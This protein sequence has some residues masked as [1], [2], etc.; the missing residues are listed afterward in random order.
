MRLRNLG[1]AL[2]VLASIAPALF[3]AVC[4]PPATGVFGNATPPD[5]WDTI[6]PQ[7]IY[8]HH[9]DDPRW[10]GAG[11]I[12]YGDGTSTQ[13]DFRALHDNA[14][15]NLF[16]SWRIFLAPAANANQNTLYVGLDRAGGAGPMVISISL[17][18]LV[19][20][21][22]V[23]GATTANVLNNDGSLGAAV[24]LP[25][26]ANTRVWI[27]NPTANSFA[28]QMQV[29]VSALSV[30]GSNFNMWYEV[31]IGT[32][33]AP[34]FPFAWPRTSFL[35]PPSQLGQIAT[36][37]VPATPGAWDA[38]RLSTGPA[39]PNCTGSGVSL[40]INQIGTTNS[41]SYQVKY[42]TTLPKPVNT[43][44][45]RA[46]N[47]SGGTINAGELHARF[48]LANW[49]SMPGDESGADPNALWATIPGGD[50]IPNA[51]AISNGTTANAGNDNHFDWTLSNAEI[52]PFQNGTRS[53][54]NCLLVELTST[55]GLT[56][57]NNSIRRNMSFVSASKFVHR[58]EISIKGLTPI[59]PLGRDVYLLIDTANMPERVTT[60]PPP[61]PPGILDN[62]L[63]LANGQQ[64][65]PAQ[66]EAAAAA[67]QITQAQLDATVPTYR[68]HVFYDS[69][70]VINGH[71]ILI[72]QSGF[73]Y[74]VI[75]DG[76]LLGWAHQTV[77]ED[78]TL[79]EIA[80]NFYKISHVPNDGVVHVITTIEAREHGQSTAGRWRAFIDAG[81]NSPDG[82]LDG[83]FSINAGLERRLTNNWSI[84]GILGY[85]TFDAI[86]DD[87]NAWQLSA[88][89]KYF[90]GSSALQPFVNGGVGIYR[91]DPP[92]DTK[93]GFNAGAGL[94]WN[95][96]AK[97]GIE[98]A[99]NHHST[100]PVD[101]STL[102]LGLRWSF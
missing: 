42:S 102:Q 3:G 40:D 19:P 65:T 58:A 98:A 4:I 11:V 15:A 63:G 24:A 57:T 82:A 28:V 59:S 13:A 49:G 48:R 51:N 60:T 25:W 62:P 92:D 54:D 77:G 83:R 17:P 86:I 36:F 95:V 46:T 74:R 33:S 76:D 55:T 7:A 26:L 2:L 100:D 66:Y 50:D 12:T 56:F 71:P 5:W 97:W 14:N 37:P 89:A 30:A 47:N 67:G 32:P 70:K 45:A 38:F 22:D 8:A 34:Q 6:P 85:H 21:E 18:T 9:L 1:I 88:N 52:V 72:P 35:G 78:T 68:V 87:V 93:V 53:S 27:N 80:P 73:G 10:V 29:P 90:F 91:I 43:F 81:G 44:F 64:M 20:S 41:P 101:W 96:N 69:G 61:P 23:A 75:H 84:E 99:Y 39:D 94:L 31:L 16:L 79:T